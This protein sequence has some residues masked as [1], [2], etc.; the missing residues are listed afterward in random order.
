MTDRQIRTLLV[1]DQVLFR[2]AVR[3]LLEN[4]NRLKVV[5]AGDGQEALLAIRAQAPELVVSEMSLPRLSGP[6]LARRARIE[7]SS[8]RFL[9]LSVRRARSDIGE[10]IKAGAGGY[11]CKSDPP[12]ELL[13]AVESVCQG[14][15]HFSSSVLAH[16]VDIAVATQRVERSDLT[17][18]EREVLR[19][20]SEGFSNKQIARHLTISARTVE[21]HRAHLMEKVGVRNVSGLIRYAI[22][23]G[24]IAP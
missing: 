3:N 7:G 23:E 24:L 22:R 2:H 5:E 14:R 19:L 12:D 21:C 1:D 15:L 13:E 4:G 16:V 6:E 20:V 18:R 9:F 8:A 17:G 11:V 10:A